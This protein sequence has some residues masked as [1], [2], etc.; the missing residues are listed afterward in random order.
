MDLITHAA[1]G[2]AGAG[3][4]ASRGS[5]RLAALTGA[6]AGLLPDL[7]QLVASSDDPLLAL[8]YH[9]H[10]THSIVIAPLGALLAA[11]AIWS[12]WRRQA[13]FVQLYAYALTGYLLSPLLDA[14]TSY[15]THLLWPVSD[16]PIA[17]SIV[18]IVD[19]LFSLPVAAALLLA[20]LR[21]RPLFA[22]IAMALAV[23]VLAVGAVQHR[24]ALD[25]AQ[26]LAAAR[27]H[28]PERVLVKPTLGNMLLWRSL[29]VARGT[30]HVD[31]IRAGFAIRV[32]PGASAP[33]YDLDRDAGLPQSS[34]QYRDAAR[35]IA[36][37]DGLPVRHPDRPEL[38]GDAR[39]AM[40][41]T[42][43]EPLW[44]IVLD[45]QSADRH[46]RFVTSRNL[47]PAVRRG[48]LAMLLGRDLD[49]SG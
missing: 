14:C 45:A 6:I 48:F 39:F 4:I 15:G 27:G 30:I 18:S 3:A 8:E 33:L 13:S 9:R 12:F 34:V 35:F 2:A 28:V 40:L 16:R 7:D 41:P 38:V 47:T 19:P 31:A 11:A 22:R 37:T 24:R 49:G 46:V 21:R 25:H 26:A 42:S 20:L 43:L 29:Y 44:G 1:L 32:Y 36:F 10:F 17:W 5:L 23:A